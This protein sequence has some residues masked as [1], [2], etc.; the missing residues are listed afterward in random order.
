MGGFVF[1]FGTLIAAWPDFSEERRSVSVKS[2]RPT[3]LAAAGK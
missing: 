3:P 1:I 2:R